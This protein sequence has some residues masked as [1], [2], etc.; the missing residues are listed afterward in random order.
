[1]RVGLVSTSLG[2][3]GAE[4][5]ASLW[6]RAC[7]DRG[8]V[9]EALVVHRLTEEYDM[10]PR[11]RISAVDK[12]S[13]LGLLAVARAVQRLAARVDVVVAF[14][15]YLALTCAVPRLRTPWA[16]V[17]G[18]DPRRFGDTSR[19]PRRALALA[20]RRA[21][22]RCAPTQGLV[23][24]HR[25]LGLG[26]EAWHVVPN[27]VAEA[28]F[29]SR[30][31]EER[32]GALWVGRLVPEKDPLL[33]VAAA[34]RAGV[35]LTVLG[36]GPLREDVV[37]AGGDGVRMLPFTPEPWGEYARH[38]V[39]LVTSRYEAFGNV[40]VE[41]LAAGTPVVAGDCDYGPREVLAGARTSSV[42]ERTP[43]A[44]ASALSKTAGRPP[45]PAERREC[46]DLAAGYRLDALGPRIVDLLE[47]TVHDL[48][49]RR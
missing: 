27:I 9:V 28:A 2:S 4:R 44:L 8:I 24:G 1:M 41:S 25:R 20:V 12:R 43:D 17:T 6:A 33:A 34:R 35:P 18:E 11:V 32:S 5:Q 37:R 19:I 48:G 29:T 3:G 21:P 49:S 15:P 45:D 31:P 7:D 13:P 47:R 16:L 22:V 26:R 30:A 36:D 46:H 38:R 39:L 42:V 10:P 23:E 14:Q 40:I